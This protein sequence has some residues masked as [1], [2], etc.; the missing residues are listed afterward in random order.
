ML[1]TE[2]EDVEEPLPREWK[3]V[4]PG[5]RKEPLFL[6][7]HLVLLE[8]IGVLAFAPCSKAF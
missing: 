4:V 8:V 6:L 1:G 5:T 3:D 2:E 7:E